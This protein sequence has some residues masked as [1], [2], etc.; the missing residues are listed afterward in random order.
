M[1]DVRNSLKNRKRM[2]GSVVYWSAQAFAASFFG[3]H[4]ILSLPH[5]SKE[6]QSKWRGWKDPEVNP[7][8]CKEKGPF[9]FDISEKSAILRSYIENKW[10]EKPHP[11]MF[12]FKKPVAGSDWRRNNEAVIGLEILGLS[13]SPAEGMAMRA[14]LSILEDGGSKDLTVHINSIGDKDSVADYE[15]ALNN[16]I[17]KN[18]SGMPPELRRIVKDSPFSLVRSRDKAFSNWREEAPKSVSFLTE[19]SRKRF[20]E[21]LEYVESFNVPYVIDP[22]LIGCPEFCSNAVFEIRSEEKT[23]ASGFSYS[24]L[25]KKIGLKREL[26]CVSTTVVV[27]KEKEGRSRL[28][29]KQRFYLV[30]LGFG[31]KL[32]ALEVIETLRTAK[33]PV[34]HSLGKDRIQSQM[35]T[36]ENMKI[37]YMLLIGQK[38]ALEKSVA[39][40]NIASRV[41]ETVPLSNLVTYLK[42]IKQ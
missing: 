26:P 22:S 15:H 42:K 8:V 34:A 7:E 17:R 28:S 37:P 20:T 29:P 18:I 35:G 24:R 16:Y 30:Q 21:V 39:V 19:A 9:G 32:L 6:D 5:I 1:K 38:E 2:D 23:L 10:N 27:K 25:S 40:R 12:S 41:Q 11:L 4:P 33:I 31:A 36:A 13:E 3:F 14:A